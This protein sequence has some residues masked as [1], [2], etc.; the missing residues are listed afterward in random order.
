LVPTAPTPPPTTPYPTTGAPTTIAPTSWG[1]GGVCAASTHCEVRDRMLPFYESWISCSDVC[2]GGSRYKL[3]SHTRWP[4]NCG[5]STY[6]NCATWSLPDCNCWDGDN[7]VT[8][9]CS[10]G[11]G[12]VECR[13]PAQC[14]TNCDS[15]YCVCMP[16]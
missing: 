2:S 3:P 12:Y 16:D 6:F 13:T 1:V 7:A 9:G 11:G 15:Q 5:E 8:S 4:P 10:S 14:G